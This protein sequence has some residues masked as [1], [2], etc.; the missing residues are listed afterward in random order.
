MDSRWQQVLEQVG[1]AT[2]RLEAAGD[3]NLPL[4]EDALT[5]CEAATYGISELGEPPPDVVEALRACLERSR[6]VNERLRLAAACLRQEFARCS[7]VQGLMRSLGGNVR[8]QEP[9]VSCTG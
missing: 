7:Q 6:R 5:R 1:C 8:E 3:A 2:T 4:L 9:Q